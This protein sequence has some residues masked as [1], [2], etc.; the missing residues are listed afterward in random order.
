[1]SKRRPELPHA[2]EET[3]DYECLYSA[4]YLRECAGGNAREERLQ[5]LKR[6]IEVG[7]YKVDPD[8]VAEH[9]LER[10]DLDEE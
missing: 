2:S 9:L 5:E 6:R 8:W 10:G 4:E 7:A 3:E 1:M